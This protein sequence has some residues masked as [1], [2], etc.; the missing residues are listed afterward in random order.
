MLTGIRYVCQR[1][2][3]KST[4]TAVQLGC[5]LALPAIKDLDKAGQQAQEGPREIIELWTMHFNLE[6][7][8]QSLGWKTAQ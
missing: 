7:E 1:E 6:S 5:R 3:N 4:S 2:I 8:V